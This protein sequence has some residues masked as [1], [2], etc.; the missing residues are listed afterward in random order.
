MTDPRTSVSLRGTC[1]GYEA[2]SD[3]SFRF[4]RD[5]VGEPLEV[6]FH[7]EEGPVPG[8]RLVV[9]WKQRPD[10]AFHGRVY[11]NDKGR[12]RLWTSDAGWF[13]VDPRQRTIAIPE[14]ADALRREVRLWTTP[15]LLLMVGR[16]DLPLH[17]S[18]VEVDGGAVLFGGPSQFGKTTLAAAFH[19]AGFRVLAEDVTCVQ[20]GRDTEVIPGP[21]LLRVRHDVADRFPTSSVVDVGED[22]ERRFLALSK[23]SRGNCDPLPL[24]G[25]MLLKSD[26]SGIRLER[27]EG[28]RAIS[29]FWALAFRLPGNEE[30]ERVFHRITDLAD[31][32]PVWDLVRPLDVD[33]LQPTVERVVEKVR[34][35]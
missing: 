20:V 25:V 33:Y 4:L 23:E 8:E 24:K 1:F 28:A 32:V 19:T 11:Q 26:A 35:L 6:T 15:M 30:R 22:H 21:A 14:H 13:L 17:A 31:R 5:G 34:E 2:H 18:A 27:R 7:S 10:K 12:Y 3:V 9:E 29:D 16:G